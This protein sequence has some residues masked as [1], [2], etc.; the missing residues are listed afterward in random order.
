MFNNIVKTIKTL[1]RPI[2]G[3]EPS[4]TTSVAHLLLARNA[5][6]NK[7]YEAA[8]NN[9]LQLAIRQEDIPGVN[10][11]DDL[12]KLLNVAVDTRLDTNPP[13]LRDLIQEISKAQ[14]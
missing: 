4:E 8:L 2:L 1:I 13:T 11:S 9:L 7:D 14:K 5:I 6:D 12:T 10:S 3:C